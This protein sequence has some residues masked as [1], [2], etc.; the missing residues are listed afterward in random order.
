MINN[1]GEGYKYMI[2]G[3][4]GEPVPGCLVDFVFIHKYLSE[5]RK[6]VLKTDNLGNIYLGHL[7]DI[8]YVRLIKNKYPIVYS[9]TEA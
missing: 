9:R 5:A 2:R 4:N 7:K 8:K 1:A 3:K 6:K